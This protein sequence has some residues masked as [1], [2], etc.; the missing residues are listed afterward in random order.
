[1]LN[2][3][4][5]VTLAEAYFAHHNAGG[6]QFPF[7]KQ[8]FQRIVNELDGYFPVRIEALPEGSTV[9][10]H[11]PGMSFHFTSYQLIFKPSTNGIV[12]QIT[13]EKEFASLVTYLETLLTMVWYPATVATLSRRCKDYIEASYERTVDPEGMWSLDSRLHDFG[14]RGCTCVEQS[15]IGGCAHLVRIFVVS[16]FCAS[17]R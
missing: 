9:Y 10:P 16:A 8:A 1:M 2:I 14:F 5:D 15:V 17:I 11:V 4:T 7:P 6:T 12:F 13:A 3:E